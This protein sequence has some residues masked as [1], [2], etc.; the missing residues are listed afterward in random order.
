MCRHVLKSF[1]CSCVGTKFAAAFEV[2]MLL[3]LF[4]LLTPRFWLRFAPFGCHLP[5][6]I[7][8]GTSPYCT[9]THTVYSG[10]PNDTTHGV[11]QFELAC[12]T[13]VQHSLIYLLGNQHIPFLWSSCCTVQKTW[14]ILFIHYCSILLKFIGC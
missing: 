14:S 5:G 13:A 4:L 2:G 12:C 7:R 1:M 6:L 10:V 9:G 8:F 3:V 11:T